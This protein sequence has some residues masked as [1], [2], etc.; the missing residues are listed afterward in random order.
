[1]MEMLCKAGLLSFVLM[2]AMRTPSTAQSPAPSLAPACKNSHRSF[3]PKNPRA[4]TDGTIIAGQ[5]IVQ[6]NLVLDENTGLRIVE[7]PRP[8]KDVLLWN[9]TIIV[10]RA[11]EE[12]RYPLRQLV[13]HGDTL[14][15]TEA[16]CLCESSDQGTIFLAFESFA[17]GA[18][19]AFAIARFSPAS[20]DV[21]AFPPAMQGRIVVSPSSP[22]KVELWSASGSPKGA[23]ECDACEKYYRIDD[24]EVVQQGVECA[25][26]AGSVGPLSPAKFAG[27]RIVVRQR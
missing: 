26:R 25:Q 11:R 17:T 2:A 6:A 15:L 7:Y 23:I 20:F 16:A 10:R 3:V 27:A 8:G 24:C 9:P 14:R 13:R 18:V 12:K 19:E 22:N 21:R 4:G 1:M 5:A